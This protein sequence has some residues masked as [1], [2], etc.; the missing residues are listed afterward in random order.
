MKIHMRNLLL[1]A[2]LGVA[3][4]NDATGPDADDRAI[5]FSGRTALGDDVYVVMVESGQLEKLTSDGMSGRSEWSPDGTRIAFESRRGLSGS[6]VGRIFVMGADGSDQQNASGALETD[7]VGPVW[8]P[9]GSQILFTRRGELHVMNADG[10][11]VRTL[12]DGFAQVTGHSWSPDGSRIV[13]V[14]RVDGDAD[15]Y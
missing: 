6:G 8:S 1:S 4:C 15:V 7:D 10:S 12:T 5:L 11:A 9:D 2:V 14:S 13:F 3:A